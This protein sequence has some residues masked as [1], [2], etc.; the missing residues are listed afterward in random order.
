MTRV[1]RSRSGAVK[2]LLGVAAIAFLV[3]GAATLVGLGGMTSDPDAVP[4]CDGKIMSVGDRCE[5]TRRGSTVDSYT[6]QEKIERQHA[7]K[8]SAGTTLTIGLTVIGASLLTGALVEIR[9]RRS[10]PRRTSSAPAGSATPSPEVPSQPTETAAPTRAGVVHATRTVVITGVAAG[11][12]VVA[13]VVVGVVVVLADRADSSEP[14]PSQAAATSSSAAYSRHIEA[15]MAGMPA[16]LRAGIE[17]CEPSPVRQRHVLRAGYLP[18]DEEQPT[19]CGIG[20]PRWIGGHLPGRE[21][22]RHFLLQDDALPG[23]RVPR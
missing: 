22:E 17:H 12:C 7:N 23:H 15:L 11:L 3:G 2:L 9:S 13:A 1:G 6:Y 8:D 18:F 20:R 16:T 19:G 4:T 21:R 5:I 14:S 10:A